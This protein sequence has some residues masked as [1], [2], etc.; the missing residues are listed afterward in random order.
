VVGR[1]RGLKSGRIIRGVRT[2]RHSSVQHRHDRQILRIPLRPPCCRLIF[3]RETNSESPRG[4]R[5]RAPVLRTM[6][7]GQG[8]PMSNAVARE[9]VSKGRNKLEIRQCRCSSGR[10][11]SLEQSL[12]SSWSEVCLPSAIRHYHK[13]A[14]GLHTGLPGYTSTWF[15]RCQVKP[16]QTACSPRSQCA[17]KAPR[18][19]REIRHTRLLFLSKW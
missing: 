10:L 3:V 8:S 16:H 1:S 4:T 11:P 12:H 15:P 9:D 6:N 17:H 19:S 5:P 14:D 7:H 2:R 13:L 18:G